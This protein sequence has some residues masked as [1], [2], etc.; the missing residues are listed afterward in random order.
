M[1]S[2]RHVV[3]TPMV[4]ALSDLFFVLFTVLWWL[5]LPRLILFLFMPVVHALLVLLLLALVVVC[6]VSFVYNG[7]EL[8]V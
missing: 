4:S 1:D 6:L 3:F 2:P 5:F 7:A 8:G